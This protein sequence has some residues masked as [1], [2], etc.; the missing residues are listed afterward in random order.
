[1]YNE[2]WE[3]FKILQLSWIYLKIHE[4]IFNLIILIPLKVNLNRIL[5]NN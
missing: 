4:M 2:Y 5:P 1:M 3:F